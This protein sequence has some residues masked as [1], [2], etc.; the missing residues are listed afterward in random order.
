MGSQEV[1][2]RNTSAYVHIVA[3]EPKRQDAERKPM[4]PPPELA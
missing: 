1:E 3:T 4:L 2:G